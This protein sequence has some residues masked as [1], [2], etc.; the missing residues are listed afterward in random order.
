MNRGVQTCPKESK[1]VVIPSC[2]ADEAF[3]ADFLG[4]STMDQSRLLPGS[5]HLCWSLTFMNTGAPKTL[6]ICTDS[7]CHTNQDIFFHTYIEL[8]GLVFT[9]PC[10]SFGRL[11]LTIC[12][13]FMSV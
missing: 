5:S 4:A 11:V 13:M 8:R 1:S 10:A 12:W 3:T 2:S 6:S 9:E 7:R